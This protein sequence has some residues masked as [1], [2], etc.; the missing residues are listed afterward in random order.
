MIINHVECVHIPERR[1]WRIHSL[2]IPYRNRTMRKNYIVI[3]N[4][5]HHENTNHDLIIYDVKQLYIEICLGCHSP[6]GFTV[7][8][9]SCFY[10]V[11]VRHTTQQSNYGSWSVAPVFFLSPNIKKQ[12]TLCRL[13]LMAD[14]LHQGLLT[15][16]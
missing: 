12:Y 1:K 5:S 10:F 9:S 16:H 8:T 7:K 3:C 14:T 13:V 4:L 11:L 15:G 2:I 6:F